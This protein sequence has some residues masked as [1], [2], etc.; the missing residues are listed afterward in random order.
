MKCPID[1]T[2]LTKLIYEA[3]VEV[4]QCPSCQG[5]WL[6]RGELF[7]VERSTEND[8][9]DRLKNSVRMYS[10]EVVS[11]NQN[12]TRQLSCPSCGDALYEKEHGFFS[13][14]MIDTCIGCRGIWLD[15][16]E[17]KALELFFEQNKP[18]KQMTF[19]C[20]FTTGLRNIFDEQTD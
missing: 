7:A 11:N 15:R 9:S 20:A 17:L 6:D 19:W 2:E 10:E 16:G 14:I 8:Y 12:K 13:K 5:I 1:Q 3:D 18:K 4:D